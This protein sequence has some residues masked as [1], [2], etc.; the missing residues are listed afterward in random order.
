M[1]TTFRCT[2]RLRQ[3]HRKNAVRRECQTSRQRRQRRLL[4]TN[5]SASRTRNSTMTNWVAN[6]QSN[7]RRR[8]R[9]RPK[10]LKRTS[11]LG[12]L[13][14]CRSSF[15]IPI[16]HDSHSPTVM[17]ERLIGHVCVFTL[18]P[19]SRELKALSCTHAPPKGA[20]PRLLIRI[21]ILM[22]S[23]SDSCL[24]ASES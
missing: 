22:T 11:F 24:I 19:H 6:Q 13:L 7:V 10:K 17:C 15:P 20:W 2:R 9:K 3:N 18:L 14:G 16:H 8:R 1:T 21:S 4:R 23:T 12:S 5:G